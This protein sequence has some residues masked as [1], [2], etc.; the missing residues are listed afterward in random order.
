[1][2]CEQAGHLLDGYLDN[3]L[4]RYDRQRLEAHLASC[5]HCIVELR[6]RSAFDQAIRQALVTSVQH[7]TPSAE[8]SMRMIQA[9]QSTV[10]QAIW[11]NHVLLTLRAAASLAAVALVLV[12]LVFLIQRIPAMM[13]IS[14]ATLQPVKQLAVSGQNSV[15][16]APVSQL[17]LPDAH[18][19]A[20]Q[21]DLTISSGDLR[22]E[23]EDLHP[24]GLFTLTLFLHSDLAQP[25]DIAH[26]VL[27]VSGPSG[28][29]RFPLTVQGPLPAHGVSIFQ[30]TPDHLAEICRKRY[31]ISP[32]DIFGEPGKYTVRVTLFSPASTP[33]Q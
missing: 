26:L 32:T 11:S 30:I 6:S 23:P 21:P 18:D 9:A 5:P 22:L 28:F 3:E 7:R 17:P 24:Q 1:M 2:N 14:P 12:G 13:D 20:T 4:R 25:V 15:A 31:S 19:Q 8:A 29:Y 33:K 10:R 16:L 27:E